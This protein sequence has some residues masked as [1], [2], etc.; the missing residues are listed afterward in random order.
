MNY[1][2]H[3]CQN[4]NEDENNS[5]EKYEYIRKGDEDNGLQ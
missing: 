4:D 3:N 1:N 5:N 2:F